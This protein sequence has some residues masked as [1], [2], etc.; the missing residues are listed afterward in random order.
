MTDQ[1][2]E[3][4]S[5]LETWY[6]SERGRYL[7]ACLQARIDHCLETAFG[8]HILQTGPVRSGALFG[9]CRI[10]HRI[11]AGER[12]GEG[13]GLLCQGDELPLESD[14]IDVIIAHHALEFSPN[15]HQVLRELQRVLTPQGQLLL[16]GWNPYSAQGL[17]KRVRGLAPHSPWRAHSPVSLRRLVDWLNLLGCELESAEYLD[18][19][20]QPGSGRVRATLQGMD[21]WCT[22]HRLP[23]GGLYLVQAIKQVAGSQQPR[24]LRRKERFIGLGVA[25]PVSAPGAAPGLPQAGAAPRN[26]G[27]PVLH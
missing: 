21:Q 25:R 5:Y 19:L 14:S 20:P 9:E 12:P 10:Q 2:N 26:Q 13:I 8:Y 4:S 7:L 11:H 22:R 3:I 23:F 6:R 24:I 27:K 15:P 1:F 18:Q 16:T 17:L